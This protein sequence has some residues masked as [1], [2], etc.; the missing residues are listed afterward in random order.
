MQCLYYSLNTQS[1]T[2]Q[3]RGEIFQRYWRWPSIGCHPTS[4]SPHTSSQTVSAIVCDRDVLHSVSHA[5]NELLTR[6]QEYTRR[7]GSSTES[8]PLTKHGAQ[9]FPNTTRYLLRKMHTRVI[10]RC[11]FFQTQQF[12]IDVCWNLMLWYY[13]ENEDYIY[14]ARGPNAWIIDPIVCK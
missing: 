5:V 8:H 12:C 1:V 9:S 4:S 2:S 7:D 11:I 13:W 10:S 14:L 3:N 6:R